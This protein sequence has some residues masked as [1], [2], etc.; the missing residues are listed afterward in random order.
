MNNNELTHR[1]SLLTYRIILLLC[2][3]ILIASSVIRKREQLFVYN[4]PHNR[5]AMI[6]NPTIIR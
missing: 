5:L 4:L 6:I 2:L 3:F 1:Q